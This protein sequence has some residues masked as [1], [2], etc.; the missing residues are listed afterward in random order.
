[1]RFFQGGLNGERGGLI[2]QKDV[3]VALLV[4]ISSCDAAVC[5]GFDVNLLEYFHDVYGVLSEIL[6]Q[7]PMLTTVKHFSKIQTLQRLLRHSDFLFQ[8]IIVSGLFQ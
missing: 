7:N 2:W 1:M 4:D 5:D 8:K 6:K 3:C